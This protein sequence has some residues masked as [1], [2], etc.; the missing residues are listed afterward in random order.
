M[1]STQLTKAFEPARRN[2]VSSSKSLTSA[3]LRSAA[4]RMSSVLPTSFG[5]TTWWSSM[6][7]TVVFGRRDELVDLRQ[8]G[9]LRLR[10]EAA[11]A[12]LAQ[13][14]RLVEDQDVDVVRLGVAELVEVAELRLAGAA[15]DDAA[16]VLGEGLAAGGVHG[17]VAALRELADEVERDD[18]LARAR[19]ALDEDDRFL[20][21]VEAIARLRQDRFERDALLVEEHEV[22][23]GLD[24]RRGVLEELA[25]GAVLRLEHRP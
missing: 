2:C 7:K 6:K 24:H 17:V 15:A 5:R 3:P 21:V 14:M 23:L 18:R 1:S 16:H 11:G 20:R 12:R 19:P 8:V 22:A 10:R 4:S 25:A 13:P 9:A